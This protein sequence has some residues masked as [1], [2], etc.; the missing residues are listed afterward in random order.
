MVYHLSEQQPVAEQ[1]SFSIDHKIKAHKGAFKDDLDKIAEKMVN[2]EN[3]L[4]QMK[5]LM[6]GAIGSLDDR[7]KVIEDDQEVEIYTE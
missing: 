7:L 6:A 2:I 4:T 5:R 3:R 1:I